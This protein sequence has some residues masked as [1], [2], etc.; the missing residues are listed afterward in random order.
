MG[1]VARVIQHRISHLCSKR[2]HTG[3]IS[4]L[5]LLDLFILNERLTSWYWPPVIN[6]GNL[7]F[8]PAFNQTN[9][10]FN[11]LQ[12]TFTISTKTSRQSWVEQ[13]WDQSCPWWCRATQYWLE[14]AVTVSSVRAQFE[15]EQVLAAIIVR[16]DQV[17]KLGRPAQCLVFVRNR[18]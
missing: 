13:G 6:L 16:D 18:H 3:L 10:P 4:P 9:S 17:L 8:S 2:H 7:S 11:T 1:G 15:T 14:P 12:P 5:Q